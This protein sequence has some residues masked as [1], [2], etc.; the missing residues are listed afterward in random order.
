[1]SRRRSNVSERGLPDPIFVCY[2]GSDA[3]ASSIAYIVCLNGWV[4]ERYKVWSLN[5][6][7][8]YE[9]HP[10][11][12]VKLFDDLAEDNF[13]S[14]FFNMRRCRILFIGRRSLNSSVEFIRFADVMSDSNSNIISTLNI[15][16]DPWGKYPTLIGQTC[17]NYTCWAYVPITFQ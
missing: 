8:V 6:Q 2:P 15:F 12:Q 3:A 1:M 9:V 17:S 13:W 10:I 11:A 16:V 4:P 5:A 14:T 7:G